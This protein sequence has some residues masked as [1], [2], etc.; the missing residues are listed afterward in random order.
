VNGFDELFERNGFVIGVAIARELGVYWNEII[1]AMDIK[2]VPR[3]VDDGDIG[4]GHRIFELS[5]RTLEVQT[6]DVEGSGYDFV[7]GLLEH[8]RDP[9]SVPLR[10]R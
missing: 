3:I 7:P 9:P 6:A 10:V 4:I 5:Y 8:I 2:P 1:R